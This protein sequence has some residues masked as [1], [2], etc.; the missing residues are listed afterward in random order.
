MIINQDINIT[1]QEYNQTIIIKTDRHIYV[2]Y[3]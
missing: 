3:F 1:Q 2:D